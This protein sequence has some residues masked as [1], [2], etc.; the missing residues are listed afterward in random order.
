MLGRFFYLSLALVSS[1]SL[2]AHAQEAEE[3]VVQEAPKKKYRGVKP[4]EADG[5]QA[6]NRF[7]EDPIIQSRYKHEGRSLEVDPD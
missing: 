7:E 5:T 4:K 6:Q 2:V 1:F 3:P